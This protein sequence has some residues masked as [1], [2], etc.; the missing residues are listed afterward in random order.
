MNTIRRT[1]RK[2]YPCHGD[3]D[4]TQYDELSFEGEKG[5]FHITLEHFNPFEGTRRATIA[6]DKED[7]QVLYKTLTNFLK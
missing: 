2:S 4:R 6:L 7:A 3:K 1:V 5:K